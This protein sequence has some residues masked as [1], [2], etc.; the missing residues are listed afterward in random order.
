M[1]YF[2]YHN[3]NCFFLE[4]SKN[5]LIAFDAG[6]P[7]TLYEY[8]RCLKVIG[9]DFKDIKIAAI[10]HMHM[11]HAGLIGEFINA[12]I[13]CLILEE[14]AEIIDEMERIILKSPEY[15]GYQQIDT[16]KN[17]A[18]FIGTAERSSC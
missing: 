14:Q 7:C 2:R 18:R 3:T 6:W 11:D 17:I 8:R 15:K 16:K 5:N 9:L 12:K 10:S 4:C 1:K 13:D